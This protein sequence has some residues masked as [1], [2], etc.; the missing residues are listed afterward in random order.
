MACSSRC[1]SGGRTRPS[2]Q[3]GAQ[4]VVGGQDY[5]HAYEAAVQRVSKTVEL[6]VH[7]Y[8]GQELLA[9]HGT[10]ARELEEQAPHLDTVL[11]AVGGG[12][13]IGGISS[14]YAGPGPGGRRRARARTD[15]A[16]GA[17]CR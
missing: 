14:W 6:M 7:A 10:V 8:D 11:V 17:C 9:G 16:R 4:T 3:L 5:A 13:L 2:R 1:R 15:V 12:G